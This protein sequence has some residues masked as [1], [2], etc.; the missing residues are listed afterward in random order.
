MNRIYVFHEI[1]SIETFISQINFIKKKFRFSTLDEVLN[2]T[3]KKNNLCHLTFDDGDISFNQIFEYLEQKKIYSTLYVSPKIISESKNYW[4]Q[5]IEEIIKKK[6][7]LEEELNK[8]FSTQIKKESY[9]FPY[10]KTLKFDE[11]DIFIKF[12]K[13]KFQINHKYKNIS[14]ME[15][16]NISS[17]KF[18]KIGAHTLNHPILSNETSENSNNEILES[19]TKL[20]NLLNCE[21]SSFAYPNG[22]YN[23]DFGKR[24]IEYVRK[25]FKT[26]VSMDLSTD[27]DIDYNFK[28]PRVPFFEKPIKNFFI[29]N[30]FRIYCYINR[31]RTKN[32][33]FN[34]EEIKRLK[35]TE[36]KYN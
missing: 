22:L 14:L 8:F 16:R 4:F 18:V 28:I 9:I 34:S 33:L 7:N 36:K 27:K 23:I 31:L 26:A 17:S 1:K 6:I 20:E 11:I 13:N 21:I 35:F 5:E 25:I 30:S 29:N 12:I 32:R 2:N 10:L 24:E 15:L 19:K 3:N